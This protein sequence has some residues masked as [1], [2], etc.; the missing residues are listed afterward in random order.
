[1]KVLASYG[2]GI[3]EMVATLKDQAAGKAPK[4]IPVVMNKHI[5]PT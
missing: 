4:R 1:M 2:S 5:K 3:L